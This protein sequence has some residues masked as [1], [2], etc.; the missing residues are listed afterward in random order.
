MEI[1]SIPESIHRG[2]RL[3]LKNSFIH[4]VDELE[5]VPPRTSCTR[6]S[7][8]PP[9][10]RVSSHQ[11]LQAN[12]DT[13][14]MIRNIPAKFNQSTFLDFLAQ[15]FDSQKINF[16]Y[17]PVDFRTRKS[18]GY[19]FINFD[20]AEDRDWFHDFFAGRKVLES[21]PKQLAIIQAKV[22]GFE[23]NYNLFK[24]SSVMTVAP[25]EY[26]PMVKCPHCQKLSPLSS[27]SVESAS[28]RVVC[29]PCA[30]F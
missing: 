28:P 19:C 20:S 30:Q 22:Q 10:I 25:P 24:A 5:S 12:P 17:L 11:P 14:V 29:S 7:S 21:S 9:R 8:A 16:Y 4:A 6:S 18:L 23:K 27:Q 1:F 15:S 26:R 3:L 2:I 13:T